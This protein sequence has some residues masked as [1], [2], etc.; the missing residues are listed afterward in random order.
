MITIMP[1]LEILKAFTDKNI[2]GTAAQDRVKSFEIANELIA[3]ANVTIL[4]PSQL[5]DMVSRRLND[6]HKAAWES[7]YRIDGSTMAVPQYNVEKAIKLLSDAESKA[8]GVIIITNNSLIYAPT[9]INQRIRITTPED[10]I[11]RTSIARSWKRRGMISSIDDAL[12]I[13]FFRIQ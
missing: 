11:S 8:R 10:F 12:W 4:M 13:S 6:D 5:Y 9:P 7:L 1:C 3:E 2:T